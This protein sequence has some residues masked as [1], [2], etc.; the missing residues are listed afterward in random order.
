VLRFARDTSTAVAKLEFGRPTTLS[1]TTWQPTP[2][3]NYDAL[4]LPMTSGV[5]FQR[6]LLQWMLMILR[7]PTMMLQFNLLVMVAS[8]TS[9]RKV[10]SPAGSAPSRASACVHLRRTLQRAMA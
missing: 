5:P 7:L 10:R 9:L 3:S 2:T 1:T 6:F 8:P 4:L